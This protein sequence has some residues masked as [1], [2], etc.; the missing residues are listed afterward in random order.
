MHQY[1]QKL[2]EWVMLSY[3][4]GTVTETYLPLFSLLQGN[5]SCVHIKVC[6][7]LTTVWNQKKEHLGDKA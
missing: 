6:T 5:V 4:E 2:V 1:L 3:Q 7:I